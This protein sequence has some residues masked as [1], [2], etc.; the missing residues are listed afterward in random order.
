MRGSTPPCLERHHPPGARAEEKIRNLTPR[1]LPSPVGTLSA[2]RHSCRE[3][4]AFRA[5]LT[6]DQPDGSLIAGAVLEA[7]SYD[8]EVYIVALLSTDSGPEGHGPRRIQRARK[9]LACLKDPAT[10]L[11]FRAVEEGQFYPTDPDSDHSMVR[12]ASACFLNPV[13]GGVG[14]PWVRPAGLA[15]YAAHEDVTPKATGL[16]HA[17]RPLGG[18]G[19]RFCTYRRELNGVAVYQAFVAWPGPPEAHSGLRTGGLF[20]AVSCCWSEGVLMG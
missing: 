17:D 3:G 4:G 9:L 8:G 13:S 14:R 18:L 10:R 1:A 11:H 7:I 12:P 16:I 20:R 19:Y 2:W 6:Q 5:A 15:E